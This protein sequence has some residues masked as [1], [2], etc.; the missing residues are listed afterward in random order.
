MDPLSQKIILF[1]GVCNLCS[2][3]VQFVLKRDHKSQFLFGSLQSDAGRKLLSRAGLPVDQFH[4]F[5]LFEKDKVYT[6][7]S[8]VLRVARHLGGG[9]SLFYV[10]MLVPRFLRDAIYNWIA[11]N[12]YR[13]FGKKNECWIPRPEWKARFLDG[14]S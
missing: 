10:F 7:S 6:R 9:W 4:S 5:V 1:D 8:A 11:R 12:R 14:G 3:T 13:W 2:A